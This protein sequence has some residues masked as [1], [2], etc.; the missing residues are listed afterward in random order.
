MSEAFAVMSGQA[1]RIYLR[2]IG[3][4]RNHAAVQMLNLCYN[5]RRYEAI[6]RLKLHPLTTA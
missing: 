5:L 3:R 6:V 1:G 2:Y 4:A